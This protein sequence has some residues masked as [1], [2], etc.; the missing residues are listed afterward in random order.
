MSQ[1]NQNL[2]RKA[3]AGGTTLLVH[4]LDAVP[5]ASRTTLAAF[6]RH[7]PLRVTKLPHTPTPHVP[8]L[9][10]P[11]SLSHSARDSSGSGHPSAHAPSQSRP[12]TDRDRDAVGPLES[13]IGL[14][15]PL[16]PRIASRVAPFPRLASRSSLAPRVLIKRIRVHAPRPP[17]VRHH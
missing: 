4:T 6:S 10:I 8:E 7:P 9:H 5:S 16:F 2:P 15:Q 14:F 1:G 13:P 17:L 11:P 3:C 12:V